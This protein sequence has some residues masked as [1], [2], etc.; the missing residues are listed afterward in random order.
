MV[1]KLLRPDQDN[2]HKRLQLRELATLNG[3]QG[4]QALR[5][6]C[7]VNQRRAAHQSAGWLMLS[8]SSLCVNMGS[9]RSSH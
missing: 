3:E 8:L 9:G 6:G 4:S 7:P 2:D 5:S 1:E